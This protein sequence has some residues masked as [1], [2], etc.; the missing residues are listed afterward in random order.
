M[1]LLS[2]P[3][4]V[5]VGTIIDFAGPNNPA[6]YLEC[7]G[8]PVSRAKYSELFA[9]LGTAW[10]SGDGSSTFNVP[11][12]RGRVAI[13]SGT[14]TAGGATAHSL[15]DKGGDQ[16]MRSHGHGHSLTL[17]NHVH[18]MAHTHKMNHRHQV[19]AG[20]NTATSGVDRITYGQVAAGSTD[21]GLGGN[22]SNPFIKPCN[23][24]TQAAS[25]SNTGNP[26]TTPGISGSISSAGGGTQTE[27]EANMP[28]YAAVRKLIKAK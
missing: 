2:V 18:S 25:T 20:W 22:T 14:G 16:R 24:N 6:G 27:A 13:G 21:Y 28:P 12:L 3:L 1:E 8:S 9:V 10:G 5:P 26:T 23:D 11:D 15:A 7:D 4:A 19:N 17:P